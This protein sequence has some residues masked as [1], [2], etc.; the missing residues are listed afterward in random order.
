MR[1][2]WRLGLLLGFCGVLSWPTTSSPPQAQQTWT[3]ENT[4]VSCHG[5]LQEPL[6]LSARFYE[7]QLSRHQAKGVTCDKCHGG[8]PTTRDLKKTHYGMRPSS[9]ADS[10]LHYRNQ[11]ATCASCHQNIVK[12]FV[13]SKHYQN[14]KGIGIGA[15][16]N[17]C[18]A[19]M[20]T[21]VITA[22]NETANLCARCHDALNYLQPRPEIPKQA[23]ET[24]TALQRANAVVLWA[25]LL[26]AQTEQRHLPHE[27][28]SAALQTAERQLVEAKINWHT[29]DLTNVRKQSDNAYQQGVKARDALRQK[30]NL[31]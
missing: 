29:F 3:D 23:A 13:Q 26:L 5:G 8:D 27:A 22:P 9:H 16:C 4:C 31:R 30:L 25:N 2:R 7:W 24:M 10:R 17:T 1:R 18:H 15:S 12:A 19:H 28:E 11:P 21:Q 14:L 20:A 6:Q